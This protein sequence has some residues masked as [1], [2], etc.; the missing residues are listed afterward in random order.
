M[1]SIINVWFLTL[2]LLLRFGAKVRDACVCD[3]IMDGVHKCVYTDLVTLFIYVDVDV[4]KHG[5][6]LPILDINT[7]VYIG[8]QA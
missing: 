3:K 5:S 4:V 2:I 7:Q 1:T 8:A 6:I